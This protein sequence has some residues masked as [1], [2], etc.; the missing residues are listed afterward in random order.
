L[1]APSQKASLLAGLVQVLG[2]F[3]AELCQAKLVLLLFLSDRVNPKLLVGLESILALIAAD[4]FL[5]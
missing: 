2:F 4:M 5:R 1:G 3:H